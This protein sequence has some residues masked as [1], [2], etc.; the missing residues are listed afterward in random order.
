MTQATG[1]SSFFKEKIAKVLLLIST[2]ALLSSVF[3]PYWWVKVKA[4]QYPKGLKV[5][6]Y[7]NHLEG[8]VQEIDSLNHYIGMRSLR[9]GAKIERKLSIFGIA[10]MAVLLIIAL[11]WRSRLSILLVLPTIFF[12]AVLRW[13]CI[14]GCEISAYI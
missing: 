4:P 1:N 6:V 11:F 7:L 5:A 2:A 12:P 9:D 8:D 10:G 3:F 14:C 13:T